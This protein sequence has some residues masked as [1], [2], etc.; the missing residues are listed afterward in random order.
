MLPHLCVCGRI[1][2]IRNKNAHHTENMVLRGFS[3]CP[4][5]WVHLRIKH[6]LLVAAFGLFVNLHSWLSSPR[7]RMLVS[8]Q[9]ELVWSLCSITK[10]SV[11]HCGESIAFKGDKICPCDWP[12]FPNAQ[13]IY[14]NG[15]FLIQICF[16]VSLRCAMHLHLTVQHEVTPA[17]HCNYYFY[18]DW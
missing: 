6:H 12:R 8:S 11:Q 14:D 5:T 7:P 17:V 1:V 16:C 2:T 15:F 13:I 10:L 4:E 18:H 9:E 3:V